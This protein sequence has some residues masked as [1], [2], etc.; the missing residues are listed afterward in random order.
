MLCN[1]IDNHSRNE[2]Q[3]EKFQTT[4]SPGG[5]KQQLK[6]IPQTR[7]IASF[8]IC[9]QFVTSCVRWKVFNRKGCE[10][11]LLSDMAHTFWVHITICKVQMGG[12]VTKPDYY[13]YYYHRQTSIAQKLWQ[14]NYLRP[15]IIPNNYDSVTSLMK[16][17]G[18]S[19]VFFI[20]LFS[21]LNNINSFNG[22]SFVIG[23]AIN[24]A[25][26]RHEEQNSHKFF[27]SQSVWINFW[28]GIISLF[29]YSWL[30]NI[31]YS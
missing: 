16:Q 26:P 8:W 2:I 20:F 17:L 9:H 29:A 18:W 30:Y 14:C 31:H 6:M 4:S 15:E 12:S 1:I 22:T 3:R 5:Q 11:S 25:I 13:Y 23:H 10:D 7:V 21:I 28:T 19:V 27:F 24:T